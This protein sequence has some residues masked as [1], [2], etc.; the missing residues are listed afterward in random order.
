M[1]YGTVFVPVKH[2]LGAS[3]GVKL[4]LRCDIKWASKLYLQTASCYHT[5]NVSLYLNVAIFKM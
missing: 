3:G 5:I 2:C 4:S 1:D